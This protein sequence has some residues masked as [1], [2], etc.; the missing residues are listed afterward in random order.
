M[1]YSPYGTSSIINTVSNNK[2]TRSADPH[3]PES[4]LHVPKIPINVCLILQLIMPSCPCMSSLHI[5]NL[6]LASLRS[7]RMQH[8]TVQG[9]DRP[10]SRVG[11]GWAAR[12]T[13]DRGRPGA[14]DRPAARARSLMQLGSAH[15]LHACMS[16]Y[17][18]KWLSHMPS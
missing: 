4:G 18:R 12:G 3:I 15:A 11:R 2:W 17:T 14:S 7:P 16:I 9:W 10:A 1:Y 13:I 8:V 6:V 5:L